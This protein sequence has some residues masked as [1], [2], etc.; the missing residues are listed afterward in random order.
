MGGTPSKWPKWP[1]WPINGGYILPKWDDPPSR[2]V[3]IDPGGSAIPL[4][5]FLKK[6]RLTSGGYTNLCRIF[7]KRTYP[8]YPKLHKPVDF[9]VFV[10]CSRGMLEFS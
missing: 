3:Q 6:K 8:K 9:R 1:K 5:F 4:H 10:V 7:L 2:L